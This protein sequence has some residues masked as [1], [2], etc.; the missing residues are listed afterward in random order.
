MDMLMG[1]FV[2]CNDARHVT[3]SLG[4]RP[5]YLALAT[6]ALFLLAIL[7]PARA[8]SAE[9]T[10]A[11]SWPLFRGDAQGTGVARSE[12][13]ESLVPLWTFKSEKNGFE[14]TA[15]MADG[16]VY[17]GSEGGKFYAIDLATGKKKWDYDVEAGFNAAAGVR[18]AMVYVGD[19]DGRLHAFEAATGKRLWYHDAGS[20]VNGGPN[21]NGDHVVFGSQDAFL[22]CLHAVTG[23]EVWKF[24]SE[25]QIR[26]MPTVAAGHAF[27]AGCD[28][29]L[30]VIALDSGK[31]TGHAD[32]GTYTGCTPA[33]IGDVAY[34]G[35]EGHEFL[36]VDWKAGKV[37][38]KYQS[39]DRE[40]P[41]R[42]S[43]A[44]TPELIVV[45]SQDKCV[46]GIDPKTGKGLWMTPTRGRVDSSP[47]IVGTRAYVG[48]ADGVLYALDCKSGGVVWQHRIGGKIQASP[49]VAA[50]RLVIGSTSGEL[51]CFGAGK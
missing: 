41:F 1:K 13:S 38:W 24:E 33:V 46:H 20:E 26:C 23:R 42:S 2:S 17:V 50:G 15:V 3:S 51:I 47:V 45:G 9:S 11:D 21:F 27:V 22:Y 40:E 8:F 6:S 19:R 28:G 4:P 10:S 48:S 37:L 16:V 5:R 49:A 29:Q 34:V 35:T 32:L 12:L 43:A 30:H 18:G 7:C 39:P 36:A 44:A 25:N 31:R 14:S